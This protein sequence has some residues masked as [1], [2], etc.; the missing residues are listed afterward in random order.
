MQEGGVKEGYAYLRE[1]L[2]QDFITPLAKNACTW[3]SAH[4]SGMSGVRGSVMKGVCAN[5]CHAQDSACAT[6][7][8]A[9]NANASLANCEAS[10]FVDNTRRAAAKAASCVPSYLRHRAKWLTG[11]ARGSF[12]TYGVHVPARGLPYCVPVAPQ[13]A[14]RQCAQC[15]FASFSLAEGVCVWQERCCADIYVPEPPYCKYRL[16][17]PASCVLYVPKAQGSVCTRTGLGRGV[18]TAYRGTTGAVQ[19]AAAAW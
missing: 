11:R 17:A 13:A 4:A 15:R 1:Y 9:A 5:S 8:A 3:S 10:C 16:R 14:C 2:L 7:W 19:A 6:V 12:T 18:R